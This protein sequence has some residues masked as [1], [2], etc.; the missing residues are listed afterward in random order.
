LGF[1]AIAGRSFLPITGAATQHVW[2]AGAVGL[3]T[4]AVMTRA[5]LG[6]VGRPLRATRAITALYLAMII[7]VC[8]RFIA[9]AMPGQDWLLHLAAGAWVFAFVGFAVVYF[10]ILTKPKAA[11][12]KVSVGINP[13]A[14]K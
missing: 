8:A 1:F 11:K 3:M 2:M 4:L 7:S 5:S 13:E 14:P 6:H 10:P 9:G 12:R